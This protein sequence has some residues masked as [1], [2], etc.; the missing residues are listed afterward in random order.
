MGTKRRVFSSRGL[1]A[2]AFRATTKSRQR[3][4]SGVVDAEV[5]LSQ[6]KALSKIT[7]R[8]GNKS[9]KEVTRVALQ[10]T[11]K[12][13]KITGAENQKKIS[14]ALAKLL[15]TNPT[16]ANATQ[17][18]LNNLR[19]EAMTSLGDGV[20]GINFVNYLLSTINTANKEIELSLAS[21]DAW[22]KAKRARK[23]K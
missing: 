12:R 7:N 11:L 8:L 18:A 13:Y 2:V 23:G 16:D 22:T 4:Q 1:R 19:Y 9:Q 15:K 5:A 10:R 20:R 3:M 21:H 17:H 14:I 6:R